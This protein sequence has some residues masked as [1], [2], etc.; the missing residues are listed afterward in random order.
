MNNRIEQ[1]LNETGLN[2]TVREESM[3]TASGI[4]IPDRKALIR[5]DNNEVLS[6]H[7]DGYQAYQNYQ[8]VEL[9]DRVS[10][11]IGLPIHSGGLFGEGKKVFIQLK[12]NDISLGSDK[13]VGYITGI[14]SFDGS[15]SL[16]FGPSNLTI[17][18]QNKFF[19]VFKALETK[20]K[21]TKNMELRIDD[22]CKGMEVAMKE[23]AKMF[24]TIKRMFETEFGAKERDYVTKTLFNVK[25]DVNLMQ[26]DSVSTTT[27]NRITTFEHDL[28]RELKEKGNTLWGLFSGVT[29]YTTHS[30]GK[31]NDSTENKM[32]GTYGNRER[33]I[34]A[35]LSELVGG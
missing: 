28:L 13:V 5:E 31:G 3:V 26:I 35:N 6:V 24:E 33:Q 8:L 23:E 9:L 29:R 11:Q 7:G 27:R 32:F 10:N 12:S 20:I 18:C 1:V 25:D 21:H 14:N 34:F 4:V 15:T 2:W 30:L 22:V 16:A 17:S 19:A